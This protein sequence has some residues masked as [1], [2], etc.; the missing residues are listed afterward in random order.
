MS[1]PAFD[2]RADYLCTGLRRAFLLL[3][4]TGA[5]EA[6]DAMSILMHHAQTAPSPP[7]TMCEEAIPAQMDA[8]VLECLSKDPLRRPASA[9][10]LWDRLDRVPLA[11][12]WNQR[13]ARAWWEMHEPEL[14]GS[15]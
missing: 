8:L 13:R 1:S 15:S 11:D 5:F 6:E 4:R 9:E 3:T 7:S 14:I 10:V 12:T 2:G